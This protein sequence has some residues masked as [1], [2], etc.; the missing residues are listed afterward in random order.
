MLKDS[1]ACA[2]SAIFW[3]KRRLNSTHNV[4][5]TRTTKLRQIST[6]L[7]LRPRNKE[8]LDK[9]RIPQGPSVRFRNVLNMFYGDDFLALRPTPKLEEHHLSAVRDWFLYTSG[10]R[11]LIHNCG[12]TLILLRYG[13]K[14]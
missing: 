13:F 5:D 6:T 10:D 12:I 8:L 14:R 2:L 3:V 11:L 9:L 4:E 1:A 7:K